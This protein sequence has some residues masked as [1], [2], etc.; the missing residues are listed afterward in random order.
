[1]TEEDETRARQYVNAE[2][3]LPAGEVLS[4]LPDGQALLVVDADTVAYDRRHWWIA[5]DRPKSTFVGVK[6]T[7][8]QSAV[9][10]GNLDSAIEWLRSELFE[11]RRV[12][13]RLV[14]VESTPIPY[15]RARTVRR[16]CPECGAFG[17]THEWKFDESLLDGCSCC[18][19]GGELDVERE[20]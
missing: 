14:P 12:F 20:Q 13:K 19:Y 15:K 5:R 9:V 16:T 8:T 6:R 2:H 7:P 3:L 11:P 4:N 18:D 1:M 10:S 17:R